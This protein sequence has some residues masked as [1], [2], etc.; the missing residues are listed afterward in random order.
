M[1]VTM[2]MGSIITL[3]FR[4]V[5]LL[6]KGQTVL[7]FVRF[8]FELFKQII[9]EMAENNDVKTNDLWEDIASSQTT[10]TAIS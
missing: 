10:Y 6:L 8:T 3:T 7:P 5:P 9:A 2:A 1:H 4:F